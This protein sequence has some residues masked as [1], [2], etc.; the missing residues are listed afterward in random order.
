MNS[1]YRDFLQLSK[2]DRGDIFV[3]VASD[4]DTLSSYIE[5]DFWV[6]LVLD[7]LFNSL[8]LGHPG[9]SFKGGT[10]LSKVFGLINRF[11]EDVDITVSRVDLGFEGDR[12]PINPDL[13]KSQ[14]NRLTN[15]LRKAVQGYAADGLMPALKEILGALGLTLEMEAD[16]QDPSLL[17][18]YPTITPE[19][20]A[21]Y[22]PKRVKIELGARAAQEPNIQGSVRPYI[23]EAGLDL[24]LTVSDIRTVTAE[25][26][27]WEKV[28]ILHGWKSRY[29]DAGQSV[30]EAELASRHYYD[31]AK[32]SESEQGR[33]A[34]E[35]LALLD[36]VRHH[37]QLM[38]P[39]PW[40][41]FEEARAGSFRV[42]PEGQLLEDIK[43]DYE[44]M[45]SMILGEGL[46]FEDVAERISRLEEQLNAAE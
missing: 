30:D 44:K 20:A 40:K 18:F 42:S 34:V 10:S 23:L 37:N 8:P 28:L 17:A 21:G 39:Q 29:M 24:D 45:R 46:P 4:L 25:R 3:T 36:A 7:V 33:S 9:L 26:T 19:G 12:D 13:S 32:L 31:V 14:R 1:A 43:R 11:S 5:K 6:C 27:F 38:F 41:K 16:T 35:D 22:V 2:A 15:K